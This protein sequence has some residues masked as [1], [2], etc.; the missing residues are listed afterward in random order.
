MPGTETTGTPAAP[1]PSDGGAPPVVLEALGHNGPYRARNRLAV[2]DVRGAPAAELSLVPSLFVN[3]TLAALR[4]ATPLPPDERAAALRRAAHLFAHETVAGRTVEEYEHD[5]SRVGGIPVHVVRI[6]TRSIATRLAAA[7]ES[8]RAAA[9]Q[10]AADDWR[11]PRTRAGRGVWTRRGGVFAVNA[12]GN[13]PGTHSLWPEALALGYRVAVR[14][15]RREPFTPHRLIT[16]LRAAGFDDDHVALLPTDH[17]RADDLLRGADLGMVYGGE[18]VVRRYAADRTVLTQGPGRSKILLTGDTDWRDHLDTIVDS[19]AH[20]GGTGCVN[21]TAVYVEGD[22]EPLCEA[23]A[24]RLGA[25]PAVPPDDDKAVLPVQPVATARAIAAHL[26]R[27]AEG[28]RAWLG[29]DAVVAE[30]GDGS[31][32]LRPAVH[33]VGRPD[34]PQTGVELPFPCVWVA[35]WTPEAGTAVLRDSLVLTVLT[36]QEELIDRLL[37]EPTISNVYVGDVPTYRIAPGLPHD[38][39][40]GEFLMRSKAVIRR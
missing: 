10:G 1:G 6:A 22:P 17:E 31:A 21:T 23:L 3:R 16:A 30:L 18:D 34:A 29:A 40:L 33:Q 11:D 2:T 7:W 27:R 12:A 15:S 28:T 38:G 20:H 35:P 25:L 5:V 37:D 8:A 26:A 24:E 4:T 32:A 39:F 14:P 19:V 13:H 36:R 9:P